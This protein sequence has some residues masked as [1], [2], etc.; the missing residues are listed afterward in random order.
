MRRG[1]P[2]VRAWR[3]RNEFGTWETLCSALA[4]WRE[5]DAELAEN[6]GTVICKSDLTQ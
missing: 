4:A 3:C 1:L 6:L 5:I 2:V